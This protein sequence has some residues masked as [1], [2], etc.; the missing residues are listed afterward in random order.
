MVFPH[1]DDPAVCL[2]QNRV[3]VPHPLG[4]RPGLGL[5]TW[6]LPVD[7]LVGIVGEVYSATGGEIGTPAILVDTGPH[8]VA[9]R[10]HI[11]CPARARPADDYGP[12]LR[13]GL[14]PIRLVAIKPYV[15]KAH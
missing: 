11:G 12:A 10:R 13:A 5:G 3:G 15:S 7:P 14:G 2:V 8:I 4:V 9:R 6:Q 1:G